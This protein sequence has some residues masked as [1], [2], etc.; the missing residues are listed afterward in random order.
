MITEF[1]GKYYF[2]SNF[3]QA[4]VMFEGLLYRNCES[5]FQSAKTLDKEQ[6]KQFCE[7][8][9]STAKKKGRSIILRNDWEKIK[10]KVMEDV[11]RDKFTRNKDLKNKLLATGERELIEGNTWNDTYWGVCR[12][13]GENKLG[14]I[15]MKVRS[16]LQE[17]KI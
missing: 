8:D 14:K 7:I 3:Y 2:L 6:R 4:P 15:L 1:R 9:P 16:E 17:D 5:A 11:V 13:K 12:E 10:D